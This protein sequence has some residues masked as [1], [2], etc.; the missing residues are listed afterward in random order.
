MQIKNSPAANDY[1]P[2]QDYDYL[3]TQLRDVPYFRGLLRAVES[4]FYR[5]LPMQS[6][7]WGWVV[8]A[9]NICQ[10]AGRGD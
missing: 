1:A 7:V 4:R 10:K 3:W 2:P 8:C 9:A 6:G 5:D